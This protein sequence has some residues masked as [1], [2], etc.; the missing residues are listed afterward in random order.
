MTTRRAIPL[1]PP[2]C[3]RGKKSIVLAAVLT[4]FGTKGGADAN[5]RAAR[6]TQRR[7]DEFEREGES[8]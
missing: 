8:R 3:G 4:P 1:G 5:A 7:G 2:S 6:A